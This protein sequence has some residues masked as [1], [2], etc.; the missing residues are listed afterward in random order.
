M[1]KSKVF[2]LDGVK[3]AMAYIGTV[4]GA[5]FATGQEILQFF[6]RYGYNSIYA[7]VLATLLFI[8]VGKKILLLGRR[9]QAPSF[10]VLIDHVFGPISPIVNIYL[11]IS[12]V[13]ICGAMFA[14]AGALLYEL[15][16]IA[17]IIG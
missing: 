14:G 12:Y 8:I 1:K 16:G 7:I 9:L 11:A 13:L 6:T 17:Y 5:G 3:I 4:I 2:I 10:G 15:F